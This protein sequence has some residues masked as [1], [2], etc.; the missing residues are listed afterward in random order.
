MAKRKEKEGGEIKKTNLSLCLIK[1][2]EDFALRK[3]REK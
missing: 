2:R 3:E 1:Y